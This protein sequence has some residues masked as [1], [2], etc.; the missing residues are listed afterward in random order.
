MTHI[1]PSVCQKDKDVV[2]FAGTCLFVWIVLRQH[3]H[4]HQSYLHQ[5]LLADT[6]SPPHDE[7]PPHPVVPRQWEQR[8]H[9]N[10]VNLVGRIPWDTSIVHR[11]ISRWTSTHKISLIDTSHNSSQAPSSHSTNLAPI[12]STSSH[13]NRNHFDHKQDWC[14]PGSTNN[15]D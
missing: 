11:T 1:I 3:R 2:S 13:Q 6:A 10:P 4:S 8:N 7:Q 14:L 15:I 9:T 5:R 12:P